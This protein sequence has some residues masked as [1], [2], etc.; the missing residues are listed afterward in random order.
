[1]YF[2]PLILEMQQVTSVTANRM[3]W[4][5]FMTSR[6]FQS[7]SLLWIGVLPVGLLHVEFELIEGVLYSVHVGV[8]L[9]DIQPLAY[10]V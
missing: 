8:W 6:G 2:S 4:C 10:T 5:G 1:M 3:L 7:S 9:H